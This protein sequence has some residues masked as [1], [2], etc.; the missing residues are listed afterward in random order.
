LTEGQV[1]AKDPRM[2]KR[3]RSRRTA[4]G[5]FGLLLLGKVLLLSALVLLV[6][7][8]GVWT[9]WKTA[10]HVMLTKGR[11]HGTMT[12][13]ACGETTCTGP[14]LPKD[15]QGTVRAKVTIDKSVTHR[16]GEQ[17]PVAVEPGTSTV[18][19]TGLAGVLHAWIPLGGALLLVALVLAGGLRLRRTAW[20]AGLAGGGLL[21]AAFLTL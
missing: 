16:T 15:G 20:G 12:V 9:S 2:V 7:T 3:S 8:A 21:V 18:V 17:I 19:R 10:Q 14:F 6:L 13:S 4:E 1:L 5:A 11:E